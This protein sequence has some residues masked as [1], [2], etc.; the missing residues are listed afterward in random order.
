LLEQ[1]ARECGPDAVWFEA[2]VTDLDA[3]RA[4]VDGTVDALGGIDVAMAN[5]GIAT[6]GA[7]RHTEL[8][9]LERVVEINLIGSI[10][11]LMLCLPHVVERRGYL[12]QVASVAAITAAPGLA[13]YS[14]SKH[15]VEGFANA[16]RIEVKSL[17]VDVGVAYYSWIDTDL[18]RGGDDR[19][20]FAFLRDQLK[21]PLAKTYPVS[22]AAEATVRGIERRTR[23][24]VFPG[25]VKAIMLAR[26]LVPFLADVQ[27]GEQMAELD[28]LSGE[29]VARLGERASRPT[30]AGGEAAARAAAR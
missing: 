10:R 24:V 19:R 2:D 16:L 6:G 28:R 22:R 15:G 17:G 4:A 26:G 25:W 27:V 14:A 30:G 18:V 7:A 12:L 9:G 11:T 23:F 5:A 13:A 20:D 29:E 1:V 8:G 21:G 3:L